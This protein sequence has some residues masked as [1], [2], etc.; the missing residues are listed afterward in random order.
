MAPRRRRTSSAPWWRR[1]PRSRR[2][3]HRAPP[4]II[5]KSVASLRAKRSNPENLAAAGL[6][7]RC[8]SRNDGQREGLPLPSRHGEAA[9][10]ELAVER[11]T[12]LRRERHQR[13]THG[14]PRGVAAEARN[15]VLQ[16]RDHRE[17]LHRKAQIVEL[18]LAFVCVGFT[19]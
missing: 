3:P 5:I 17:F 4:R 18:R 10:V 12:L 9:L 8:A 7:R 1:W 11:G 13:W 15:R 2:R 16:R 14:L 6:L 19:P